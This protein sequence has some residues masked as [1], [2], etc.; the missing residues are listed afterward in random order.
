VIPLYFPSLLFSLSSCRQVVLLSSLSGET[1]IIKAS[2]YWLQPL[3]FL[4]C[5]PRVPSPHYHLHISLYDCFVP[6]LLYMESHRWV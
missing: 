1:S 4:E 6:S 3:T 5:T 2:L